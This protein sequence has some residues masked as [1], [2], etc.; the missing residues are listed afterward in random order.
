MKE[1]INTPS[2]LWRLTS[3]T[4]LGWRVGND[5]YDSDGNRAG[6]FGSHERLFSDSDGVHV[7]STHPSDIRRIGLQNGSSSVSSGARGQ[8]T[9]KIPATKEKDIEPMGNGG[10]TDPLI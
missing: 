9:D 10:W 2:P 5:F 1:G 4:F 7:G 3:G 6:Y 8:T